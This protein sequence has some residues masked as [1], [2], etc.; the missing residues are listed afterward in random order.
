MFAIGYPIIPTYG[1]ESFPCD[2][3]Q[4]LVIN[5]VIILINCQIF[6]VSKSLKL[7]YCNF[8]INNA[9]LNSKYMHVSA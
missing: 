5:L 3:S 1:L 4:V 2:R 7:L 9:I 8:V 6:N